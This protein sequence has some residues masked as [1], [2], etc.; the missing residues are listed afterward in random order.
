MNPVDHVYAEYKQLLA[1][2]K[3]QAAYRGIM[4]FMMRL[5]T[6]L[7]TEQTDFEVS[8]LYQGY[9][10]MTYFSFTTDALSRLGLK[11]AIVFLHEAFG[12]QVWLSARN[13]K[14]QQKFIEVLKQTDW[15][16]A[17]ISTAGPGI[18]SIVEN[19]LVNTPD[20][21]NPQALAD[22][23]L[24]GSL[25]FSNKVEDVLKGLDNL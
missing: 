16:P 8:A 1:Q 17:E 22:Q 21:E 13:R 19:T 15:D 23:I 11:I 2:G 7:K 25:A 12:F 10:D 20:F 14:L 6:C 9:M 4:Q 5:Q 24:S 3:V 18:D